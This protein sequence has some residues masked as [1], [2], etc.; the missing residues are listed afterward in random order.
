MAAY[1]SLRAGALMVR[2]GKASD[3]LRVLDRYIDADDHG[4]GPAALAFAL[5]WRGIRAMDLDDCGAARSDAER[6]IAVAQRTGSRLAE[7]IT[8]VSWAWS[9]PD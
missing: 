6:G 1:A 2:R 4:E 5:Y 9:S 8:W 3:A 7:C